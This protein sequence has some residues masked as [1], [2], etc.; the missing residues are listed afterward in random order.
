MSGLGM[1]AIVQ[2]ERLDIGVLPPEARAVVDGPF[3]VVGMIPP[4][5]G[6]R[7]RSRSELAPWLLAAQRIVESVMTCAPVL[8][9]SFGTIADDDATVQRILA[10]GHELF[11][12]AFA[13]LGERIEI[14]LSVL[15]NVQTIVR[16]VA[17]TGDLAARLAAGNTEAVR[18]GAGEEL[19]REIQIRR[20]KLGSSIL[21][22]LR[23]L[24]ADCIATAPAEPEAVVNLALLLDRDAMDT[25]ES[26][27]VELDERFSGGLSFRMVGPMAPYSFAS[28]HIHQPLAD[29]VERAQAL[30]GVGVSASDEEVRSAYYQAARRSHPDLDSDAAE[31][32]TAAM[33]TLAASY[34]TLRQR[35]LSVSLLRLG[36]A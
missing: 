25:L 5:G 33:A 28:V 34:Q 13:E 36:E 20:E 1:L 18:R 6:M 30:L 14:D 22:M 24:V 27:L 9:V 3:T 21:D 11:D 35:A 16:E 10:E 23:P 2:T 7:G 29:E 19:M 8:P 12:Q 4:S 31:D 17:Q 26:A 32:L 15:W